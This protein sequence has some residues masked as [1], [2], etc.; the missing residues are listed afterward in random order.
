[1][2]ERSI[3]LLRIHDI[4]PNL[5]PTPTP[6]MKTAEQR[7]KRNFVFEQ[8][9][10]SHPGTA[11]QFSNRPR[12]IP[13]TQQRLPTLQPAFHSSP[14]EPI[15]SPLGLSFPFICSPPLSQLTSVVLASTAVARDRRRGGKSPV[16]GMVLDRNGPGGTG[17]AV[18][19]IG[20]ME[21]RQSWEGVDGL[22]EEHV[23]RWG[24][25][26]MGG[27]GWG[28]ESFRSRKCIDDD[29]GEIYNVEYT[30]VGKGWME[31][32]CTA[33]WRRIKEKGQFI[34]SNHHNTLF[35]YFLLLL[36]LLHSSS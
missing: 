30:S 34:G 8:Q 12:S 32:Y 33:R 18:V 36:L 6:N 25:W 4:E 1:M 13:P 15:P 17:E 7:H 19:V 16:E 20:W 5:A 14:G 3:Q 10:N 11:G 24:N 9:T 26:P 29:V 23:C 35:S 28:V 27:G 22:E 31:G 2:H 21:G